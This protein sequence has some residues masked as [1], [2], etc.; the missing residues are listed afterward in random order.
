[1]WLLLPFKSDRHYN[2]QF[3][4]T[5]IIALLGPPVKQ[6]KIPNGLRRMLKRFTALAL[7]GGEGLQVGEALIGHAFLG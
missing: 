1:M 3:S 5:A 6:R 2:I 4:Q 7:H